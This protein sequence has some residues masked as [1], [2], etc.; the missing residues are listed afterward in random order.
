MSKVR[1]RKPLK[2][3]LLS[4]GKDSN[5]ILNMIKDFD[6]KYFFMYGQENQDKEESVVDNA[7]GIIKVKID[8]IKRLT[9]GFYIARN[10]KFMQYVIEDNEK[11]NKIDIY[12]GTNGEDKYPDNQ[13]RFMSRLAY[14]LKRSYD[15]N[16][17][18]KLPLIKMTKRE[19]IKKLKEYET[20]LNYV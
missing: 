6:K 8:E 3:L 13:K 15:K 16:I 14:V 20:G 10:M 2:V 4:G 12:I 19:I 17:R 7:T 9:N 1:T 18:I 5:L 11:E